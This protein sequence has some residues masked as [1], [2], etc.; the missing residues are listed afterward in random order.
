MRYEQRTT[1]GRLGE[2]SLD[3]NACWKREIKETNIEEIK[4]E[5]H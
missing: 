5:I 2:R 1:R 3:I 4:H